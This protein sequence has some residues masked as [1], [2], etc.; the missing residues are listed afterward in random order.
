MYTTNVS[1]AILTNKSNANAGDLKAIS[2]SVKNLEKVKKNW[3]FFLIKRQENVK[4]FLRI[5][6]YFLIL[7]IFKIEYSLKIFIHAA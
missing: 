6:K 7:Y 3:F 4:V 1:R 2:L 5:R